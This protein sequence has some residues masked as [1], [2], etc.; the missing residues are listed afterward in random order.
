VGKEIK[1]LGG[2]G[3]AEKDKT[4]PRLNLSILGDIGI[5]IDASRDMADKIGVTADIERLAFS[6]MTAAR[7]AEA[8]KD[9]LGSV[10]A[11]AEGDP[12][13]PYYHNTAYFVRHVRMSLGV[14][15]FDDEAR[16]KRWQQQVVARLGSVETTTPEAVKP[17]PEMIVADQ[18][19]QDRLSAKCARD[20]AQAQETLG[21]NAIEPSTEPRLEKDRIKLTLVT[22]GQNQ[23]QDGLE[24]ADDDK[25]RPRP[26]PATVKIAS[27]NKAQLAKRASERQANEIGK[28]NRHFRLG[29]N[30]A[31][32]E[33]TMSRWHTADNKSGIAAQAPVA[34]KPEAKASGDRAIGTV[35]VLVAH[36]AAK[37]R[38]DENNAGSYYLTTR[39]GKG[40][41]KTSWGVDLERA[42]K[43]SGATVGDKVVVA[44]EG[45]RQVTVTVPVRDDSGRVVGYEQK[46]AWRNGW[47]VQMAESFAKEP[48]AEAFKKYPEL[49]GAYATVAG[50]DKKA[51]ADGLDERRRAIVNAKVWELFT[52]SI[53]RGTIPNTRL[54]EERIAQQARRPG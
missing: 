35:G 10:E 17:A 38:H 5:R 2:L 50:I 36:G 46:E 11:Q 8:L 30:N 37:Y 29:E 4:L 54:R 27:D 15:P 52:N 40:I 6:G 44:N 42:M 3:L 41:E 31:N 53:E 26:Q 24:R 47:H 23:W 14:P 39:D 33:T 20:T 48:P 7:I 16:F 28:G 34:A 12:Q 22:D 45:Q 32:D 49:A 19:T 13:A 18:T 43:E 25:T 51:E 9:R 21:L 1:N